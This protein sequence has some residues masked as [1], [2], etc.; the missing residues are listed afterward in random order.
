MNSIDKI[1][2]LDKSVFLTIFGNVFE[3]TE[4]ISE[5]VFK[6]KPFKSFDDLRLKMINLFDECDRKKIMKILNSHPELAVEKKLTKDSKIEQSNASLNEC[7]VEE[8]Q[9]FKKLN[10]QYKNKFKFPFIIAVSDKS[11][12]EILEIFKN[13]INNSIEHEFI[14]AQNQ[15][16]KIAI[17]RFNNIINN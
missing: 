11:R 3:K 9:E 13:R 2:Q 5:I 10:M 4:W 8:F 6:L 15:V 17:T 1:N 14:E 12:I 7:T 16:K